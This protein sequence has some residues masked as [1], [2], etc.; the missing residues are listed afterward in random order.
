MMSFERFDPAEAPALFARLGMAP[1]RGKWAREW[2]GRPCGC[3]L[4]A[5]A[6][7]REPGLVPRAL[8]TSGEEP[9]YKVVAEGLGFP[10]DYALG[11]IFGWDGYPGLPGNVG[12]LAGLPGFED[13]RAAYSAVMAAQGILV[14][15]ITIKGSL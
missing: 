4:V 15:G 10:E 14:G 2:N 8:D 12:T 9:S 7:D 11:I 13:G 1:I 5:I 6:S 3:L